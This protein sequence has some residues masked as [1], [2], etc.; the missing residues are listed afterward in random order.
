LVRAVP[1]GG[2]NIVRGRGAASL[3]IKARSAVTGKKSWRRNR[4]D[5]ERRL[6]A[7]FDRILQRDGVQGVGINPVV[8]E[9]GVGK[10][11]LYEYFGGLHGLA[12]AWAKNTQFLPSDEEVGGSDRQLY[13]SQSTADQLTGNYR[14]F[15]R[16]LRRRPRTLEILANELTQSTQLTRTLEDIR[17]DYGKGLAKYFTRPEEYASDEA[18]ALQIVMYAAVNYLAMRSRTSPRYFHLRLDTE[19]G[20]QV[21]DEMIGQV[22]ALV[23]G[24]P[25]SS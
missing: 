10:A 2:V 22:I 7:A 4:A 11:L 13:A 19:E 24:Q 25:E 6:I 9:A 18:I 15:A 5:K 16:A 20:W 3:A 8:K 14:R 21:I 1:T 23:L 17:S 12:A